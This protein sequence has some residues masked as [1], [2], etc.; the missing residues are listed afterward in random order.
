MKKL[1]CLFAVVGFLNFGVNNVRAVGA[2][3]PFITLEAESGML[4]GGATL[5]SFTPGTTVPTSSSLELEASGR[6]LVELA[7][8][9]ASVTLTNTGSSANALVIRAS[10]PDSATG[11]GVTN[12]LNM[13]VD[14]VFR[15]AITL[16]S[17]QTWLYG[18]GDGDTNDPSQGNAHVFYDETRMFITGSPIAT[19][20][21]IT[22]EKDSAN[23]A[24]DYWIDC[25]DLE[26][27]VAPLTQPANSLSI[28]A[29]GAA[30]NAADNS[31]A[32]QNCINA[33][34]TQGE[35]VWIPPGTFNIT[36]KLT[37]TGITLAGAG[38]W[39]STIYRN[40]PLPSPN[41]TEIILTGGTIQDLYIDANA[42][43][44]NIPAYSDYGIN[45]AGTGWLIQRVWIQHSDAAIW[46]T[47]TSGTVINSRVANSFAD[48]ININD[49]SN[50]PNK[51]GLNLTVSNNFV[52]GTGDDGI[53]INSQGTPIMV[54]PKVVN[55]TSVGAWWANGLRIAGGTN[56]L[57]QGNLVCDPVTMNGIRVGMYGTTGNPLQSALVTGNTVLRGGGTTAGT[58]GIF[59]ES[60]TN[61]PLSAT[62]SGNLIKDSLRAG[63]YVALYTN[64]ITFSNNVIDHPATLGIDIDPA[65]FGMGIFNNNTVQNLNPGQ[66]A[67]WNF[68]P[69]YIVSGIN[70]NGFST[71]VLLLSQDQPVTASSSQAG[72]DPTN[73]NDGNLTTTRWS[74]NGAIYP[75]W[76][77]LDLGQNYILS[78]VAISWYGGTG[79]AYQ[80]TIDVS[81]NDVNYTTVANETTNT[82]SSST[83]N[84]VISLARYVRV[85]VTGVSPSGGYPSF[86]ECQVFGAAIAL[87]PANIAT[88]FSSNT[89]ALS[90]PTDHLGWR[91]QVQT[92]PL[93]TGLGANWVT[94]PGSDT[95]TSTNITINP[96]GGAVFYR[97]A[98]P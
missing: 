70:D 9:G 59:V 41:R 55:N 52:R 98:S 76:W 90:W 68:S 96:T 46:A 15:Q 12:M 16:S 20:S 89:I 63:L 35:S 57:V 88:V 84:P 77:R 81:T 23:T 87:T 28:L 42:N 6:A 80:Y 50:D 54:N 27:V 71:T 11:N 45:V 91:L 53:A 43:Q 26:N 36:N 22:F 38:V 10:I 64:N 75:S 58:E 34:Q 18:P 37:V 3:T 73:A 83:V 25:I 66:L 93:G 21:T 39:Y 60:A 47:G 67:F 79:R 8:V 49:G 92:N 33:A 48:G 30:T 31:V 78:D 94:L 69:N 4:V 61:Y 14:G 85:T 7:V 74:A 97:L 2:S 5:H 65:A 72:Y 95:I 82:I 44:R 32:I 51:Q 62:I 56:D 86:Y 29:Y 40:P 1:F 13:Y 17:A 24:D 19:G